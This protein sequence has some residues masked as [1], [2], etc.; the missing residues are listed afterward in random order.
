MT[1]ATSFDGKVVVEICYGDG[2]I[3]HK[4]NGDTTWYT[5]EEEAVGYLENYEDNQD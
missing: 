1:V 4:E 3:V 2:Y 5:C